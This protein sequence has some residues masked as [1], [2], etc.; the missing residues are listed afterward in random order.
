MAA[1]YVVLVQDRSS[2]EIHESWVFDSEQAANECEKYLVSLPC[3][4]DSGE[5]KFDFY[6]SG[7]ELNQTYVR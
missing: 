4:T 3:Y 1:I 7:P 6:I 2:S 5:N